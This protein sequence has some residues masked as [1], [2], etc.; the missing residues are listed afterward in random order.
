ML[1]ALLFIGV[2]Y[3][4]ALGYGDLAP[5]A[6]L[7]LLC[8]ALAALAVASPRWRALGHGLFICTALALAV[9]LLPGFHNAQVLDNA[10]LSADS[11]PYSFKLN[12]DKPL[13]GLWLLLVCPWVLGVPPR[14][15]PRLALVLGGTCLGV[16]GLAVALGVIGWA[17]KWPD[18]GWLWLANNLLLV[19]LTEELLFRGYIQ[20]GLSR[21]LADRRYGQSVALGASSLLFGLAHLGLGGRWALLAG[22]AG[23]GY[24]LA[25]RYGGLFAALACHVLLNVLHFGL[26][27]YPMGCGSPLCA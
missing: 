19:S 12:L 18:V 22:L 15:L 26:F 20:G 14:G 3:A 4:L 13:I 17:P 5:E 25:W 16:L 2:G 10:R 27:S 21:L 23:V 1:L 9:H 24:G 11:V 7:S 6:W 8:L